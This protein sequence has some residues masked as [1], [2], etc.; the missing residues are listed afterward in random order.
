[1][2]PLAYLYKYA[3]LIFM[4]F[5]SCDS[6]SQWNISAGVNYGTFSMSKL[7]GFQ[8]D[9]RNDSNY[10]WVITEK[11][12]SYIGTELKLMYSFPRASIGALF[13]YNSTGGRIHYSDYSGAISSDQLLN[14]KSVAFIANLLVFEKKSHRI[15]ITLRT[16]L[17]FTALKLENKL[18]I[19]NEETSDHANFHSFGALFSPGVGYRYSHGNWFV[20]SELT[21]LVTPISS[22]L[23]LNGSDEAYIVDSSNEPVK[24]QWDGGR[25]A[26][27]IG[28]NFKKRKEE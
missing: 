23:Y 4:A 15:Y 12:P 1:M 28:Y 9:I 17:M 2:T 16:G 21:G 24:A 8:K 22:P 11:F 26:I 27:G 14:N 25:L 5:I 13:S 18:R 6:F 10:P 3:I 19:G 20:F 7:K